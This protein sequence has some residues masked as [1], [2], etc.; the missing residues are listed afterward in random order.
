MTNKSAITHKVTEEVENEKKKFKR[1][2]KSVNKIL[3]S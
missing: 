2:M 3:H 1:L